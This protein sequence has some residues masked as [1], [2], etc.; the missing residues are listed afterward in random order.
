MIMTPQMPENVSYEEGFRY[1]LGGHVNLATG[2]YGWSGAASTDFVADPVN[3]MVIL[4]FTQYTPFMGVPFAEEY[5]K[6]V[7]SALVETEGDGTN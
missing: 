1:G 2:E 4:S 6:M 7:R 3:N 5:R